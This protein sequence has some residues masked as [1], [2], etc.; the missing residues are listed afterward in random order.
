MANK[1]NKLISPQMK[2]AITKAKKR[3]ENF[4]EEELL[5]LGLNRYRNKKD[6]ILINWKSPTASEYGKNSY[7]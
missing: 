2:E 4:T 5:D 1:Q 3:L 7:N 6:K